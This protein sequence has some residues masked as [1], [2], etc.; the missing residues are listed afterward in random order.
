[1]KEKINDWII[2][3]DLKI[4]T[5]TLI[6]IL[7]S[8]LIATNLYNRKVYNAKID[9]LTKEKTDLE[10]ELAN[11]DN[12][13]YALNL[14]LAATEKTL[15]DTAYELDLLANKDIEDLHLEF[16][17]EYK[18]TAYCCEKYPHICGTGSGKTASGVP[19]TQDVTV[20]VNDTNKFPFGTILYIEDV[21]IRIV[22]D[23]GPFSGKQI[24][25][26][27]DTHEHALKW[28]GQGKHKVWIVKRGETNE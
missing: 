23:T 26:A 9:L 25:C 11:K 24:D 8:I 3:N 4:A 21:G 18:C 14:E 17:G 2:E 7:V 5:V 16:V 28:E 1:M 22:Q 27:V 20:A 13:I 10:I 19:I 6:I 12:E 15:A